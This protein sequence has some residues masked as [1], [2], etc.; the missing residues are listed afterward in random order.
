MKT[1]RF[2]LDDYFF[3]RFYLFINERHRKKERERGT[4]LGRGRTRLHARSLMQDS[5]PD[6]RI[7]P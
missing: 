1:I 5:I 2:F 6:P 3:K 4:D 7:I